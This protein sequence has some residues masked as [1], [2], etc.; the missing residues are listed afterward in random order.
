MQETDQL[1]Q[2]LCASFQAGSGAPDRGIRCATLRYSV[3]MARSDTAKFQNVRDDEIMVDRDGIP[4]YTRVMPHLMKEYKQ[5]VLFAH[6]GLEG[7][8]DTEEKEAADLLKGQRRFAKRL[9]DALHGE[10][11][12][13]CQDL[14]KEPEKLRVPKGYEMVSE[15]LG[16]IE[17]ETTMRKT[18]AF[19]KFFDHSHRNKPLTA[20]LGRRSRL[21]VN[22][23]TLMKQATFRKIFKPTSFSM[24]AI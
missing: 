18:E 11:W 2:Q 17:K 13:A 15:A 3:K 7:E 23:E 5:R 4:H 9:I 12:T 8:G 14:L 16:M 6:A 19:G 22:Y 24:A 20:T 10:A 21:G 1:H